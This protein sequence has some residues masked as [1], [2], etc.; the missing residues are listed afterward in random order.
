LNIVFQPTQENFFLRKSC[1]VVL[2]ATQENFFL[3]KSCEV[4]F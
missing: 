3:R 4:D 2:Q 1:E